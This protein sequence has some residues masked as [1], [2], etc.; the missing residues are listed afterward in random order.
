MQPHRLFRF[1]SIPLYLSLVYGFYERWQNA[2]A[3]IAE[4]TL[5]ARGIE[6]GAFLFS[7]GYLLWLLL[8]HSRPNTFGCSQSWQ[9]DTWAVVREAHQLRIR[10]TNLKNAYGDDPFIRTLHENEIHLAA[11]PKFSLRDRSFRDWKNDFND[12]RDSLLS[13]VHNYRWWSHF[14]YRKPAFSLL[15]DTG[16]DWE[17]RLLRHEVET[18]ELLA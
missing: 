3:G 10:Y 1:S 16:T 6:V 14:M 8:W 9:A 11:D 7:F 18:R 13:L 2:K 15:T 17:Q 5:T 4:T 12:H